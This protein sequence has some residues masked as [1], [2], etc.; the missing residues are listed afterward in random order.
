[1]PNE[2]DLR[3]IM[4]KNKMEELEELEKG[5][6]LASIQIESMVGMGPEADLSTLA[7]IRKRRDTIEEEYVKAKLELEKIRGGNLPEVDRI[8]I[9]QQK[10]KHS[11]RKAQ[12]EFDKLQ[13][14]KKDAEGQLFDPDDDPELKDVREV[15]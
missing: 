1:M 2:D 12:D 3:Q 10:A 9:Q 13:D 14:K 5:I 8:R 7:G 6:V 4:I 15:D 11:L